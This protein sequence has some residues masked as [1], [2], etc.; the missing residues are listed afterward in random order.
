MKPRASLLILLLCLIGAAHGA[1]ERPSTQALIKHFK[2]QRIPDEGPWFTLTYRS[3][4]LLPVSE[5]PK[6]YAGARVA[7]NAIIALITRSEF[8]ALHKLKTDE[9]WHYYLG[10]P[11]QLLILHPDGSGEVVILGPDVLRGQQLQHVVPRGCWQGAMPT[12][13][14]S[15]AYTVFGDTLAPG[16]EYS[17]FEMGYREELQRTYPHYAG[18]IERLTRSEFVTR[19]NNN[20][21]KR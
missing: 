15:D 11:L 4:D 13:S 14:K 20:V 1:D 10:D 17:D 8:S 16:F 12:R 7:G 6:R 2:M 3:D 18:L 9:V 5:L 21:S 19:P